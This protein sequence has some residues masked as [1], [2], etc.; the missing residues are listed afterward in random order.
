MSRKRSR[1]QARKIR[2]KKQI[3]W[4]IAGVVAVVALL[5]ILLPG[6]LRGGEA[7]DALTTPDP[8]ENVQSTPD[9]T[10]SQTIDVENATDLT[11]G[12]DDDPVDPTPIAEP[13]PTPEP[14]STPTP[15]SAPVSFTISAVGDCTLG[16]D[17]LGPSEKRFQS[18]VTKNGQIDYDHCFL[19][20]RDIFAECDLT[21]ANFEVVL[22]ES[23]NMLK[24][25]KSKIFFLRGKP[26]YAKMLPA[27]NIDVVTIANNHINDFGDAGIEETIRHLDEAGIPSFG[28]ETI[29]YADVKGVR[30]GLV[31]FSVWT[32]SDAVIERVMKE[33][34]VN[35]DVLIASYHWGSE[36]KYEATP[37]QRKYGRTAV[38]LGADLVIGHH[39][40]VINGIE[41]YKG[42]PIIY[43]LGN[44]SFGGK[45]NPTDKDT[46]IYQH[47]FTVQDGKI[48]GNEP[49]IIPCKI[50]SSSKN[51]N[52]Q[53]T[54]VEGKQAEDIIKKIAKYSKAFPE[55]LDILR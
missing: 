36:L 44:F 51:N 33:A 7:P 55:T 32:T 30:V 20:V 38:D 40:H 41:V 54:P 26:E 9:V 29:Y 42:V 16:G 24:S 34:R 10:A 23:R 31:G 46:F 52:F 5:A 47:T 15:V 2:R 21:I 1:A 17:V 13:T 8:S 28:R 22:T 3:Q 27:G 48:I 49:H 12:A 6:A 37:A 53:P 18:I 39:P 35:C 45:E 4:S 25:D 14:T 50:T 43:S 19:N 11:L